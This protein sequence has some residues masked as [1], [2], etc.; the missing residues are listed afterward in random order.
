[1]KKTIILSILILLIPVMHISANEDVTT[2]DIALEKAEIEQYALPFSGKLFIDT[3]KLNTLIENLE[4][5][6]Y[7]APVDAT[8]D[9]RGEIMEGEP[10]FALDKE[11]FHSLFRKFFYTDNNERLKVPKR[12][13]YPNVDSELLAEI[14]NQEIGSYVTTFKEGNAERSH[15]IELAAEAINNVVVFS[16]KTF[17]FNEVVGERTEERGYM[18]APVI[19]KG[20][21]AEDVGG[22]ICQ[23]SSTLYN[24]VDLE[25]IEIVER[26][27]HSR[28]VPYV[29]PGRDATV[30][31]WGPDFAFKNTY[32]QP[33]LLR[34]KAENGNMVVRVY[35]SDTIENTSNDQDS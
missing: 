16:G 24:A 6:V 18:R 27:E 33:I 15:N 20:E 26:Y 9:E 10:G 35:A 8:L 5:K 31:W 22:G 13:I 14:S 2:N 3:K 17:S 34:A 28:S 4:E 23:V 29:P 19:V 30:S 7:Q 25:G 12:K 1:M 11:K 21:L 32:N